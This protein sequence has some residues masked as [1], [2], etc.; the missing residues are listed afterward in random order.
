MAIT[1]AEIRQ[2]CRERAD[3]VDSEFI[4]DSD[5]NFL[6]NSS[7]AEL[8]D[9]L[10]QEYG[11]D[12]YLDNVE[13]QTVKDQYDYSLSSITLTDGSGNN[14]ED[15][16]YKLRGVDAKL[17]SDEYFSLEP[18]M[19]N[20]RNKLQNIGSWNHLGLTTVRYR[21]V[22]NKLRFSPRPDGANTVRIWYIPLALK[23]SEDT[24]TLQDFNQYSEYVIENTVIHMLRKEESDVSVNLARKEELKLRITQA[25]ANRD[26][27]QPLTVED[28]YASNDDFWLTRT[29]G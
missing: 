12:Y 21:L 18:F 26:A 20:E 1:L 4:E 7:I 5:I 3:M 8:H 13:F 24:D 17:T 9:I 11:Q 22:G 25:A 27:G 6:I 2:Q 16:F 10:I 23:L 28:V 19:F 14:L 29:K 15:V